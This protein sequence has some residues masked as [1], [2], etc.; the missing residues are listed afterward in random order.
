MAYL[1]IVDG[2]DG[3][4][5]WESGPLYPEPEAGVVNVASCATSGSGPKL[6]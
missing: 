6:G 1:K 2:D 5:G 4:V 3:A